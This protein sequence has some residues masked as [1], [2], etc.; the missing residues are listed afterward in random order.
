[1][2]EDHADRDIIFTPKPSQIVET[3][4]P[5]SYWHCLDESKK[6]TSPPLFLLFLGPRVVRVR[7]RSSNTVLL[8]FS[9]F[10]VISGQSKGSASSV[11]HAHAQGLPPALLCPL[12]G[13]LDGILSYPWHL[14][15]THLLLLWCGD[16]MS[17]YLAWKDGL[18]KV[19]ILPLWLM[20]FL[21]RK[22][23]KMQPT[24]H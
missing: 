24:P 11:K 7:G 14:A 10:R 8:R 13:T 6:H 19:S 21:P 15:S 9:S 2:N 12:L 3:P 1:M 17:V 5:S 22:T 18:G 20:I 23:Y 4:V 16:P